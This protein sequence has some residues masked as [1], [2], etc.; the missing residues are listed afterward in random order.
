HD[1]RWSRGGGGGGGGYMRSRGRGNF[2]GNNRRFQ[3]QRGGYSS[4]YRGGRGGF[5]GRGRGGDSFG[6][7]PGARLDEEGDETMGDFMDRGAERYNPYG[8]P[9]RGNVRGNLRFDNRNKSAPDRG[10]FRRLGLPIDSRGGGE[11]EWFKI[12]IPW[13]K[14]ADKEFILKQINTHIDTPFVPTYFHFEDKAAVF[15]VNDGRAAD[16]IRSISKQITMPNGYKMTILVKGSYPPNIPMG[17]DEI[18]KLKVAMS[19]RYD[20]TT[21]ALNLSSL[22]SDGELSKHELYM[23][24][25]RAQV[26]SNVVK[27]ITENIPELCSLDLSNNKL[28]NLEHLYSLVPATADMKVLNLSNN[29][30]HALED[31]RKLQSWKLDW[32]TLTGN[33]LCDKFNDQATY[34]SAV[35]KL[36]PKLQK[37]DNNDLPPAITFDIEARTDLPKSQD[38][39]FP[40]E[41]IKVVA[42][43]FL[44]DYFHVYDSDDRQGLAPAYHETAMFSLSTAYNGAVQNK[45][46]PPIS[47]TYNGA[48]QNKQMSLNAYIDGSRNLIK[49]SKDISRKLKTLKLGP[50]IVAQLCLLPKSLHD[51]NSFIVDVNFA[52]PEM[53][54]FTIQ[55]VFKEV[56][57][58]MDRPPIR[59]FSRTFVTVP[60]GAGMQIVNDMLTVTNASPDQVQSAFKNPAP[61]PSSSPV[62]Q[63]SPANPFVKFEV[64]VLTDLQKQMVASFMNDSRMNSEWSLKCLAQNGWEYEQAGKNFLELQQKGLIPA[65]AFS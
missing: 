3:S 44:K 11:S 32:L 5:R 48:V 60:R 37:L 22:H 4:N 7:G 53:M 30:L 46:V 62:P 40:S 35:R 41:D 1:D 55:G 15:Y 33:P 17:D 25:A 43:K 21:K 58:K 49:G 10:T 23:A 12:L 28:L 52:S 51:P 50:K 29:K 38:S 59:A 57:S 18:Q 54:S 39:Y 27:I 24:L 9:S 61:T 6:P 65:E 14:K 2:R 16:A 42:V 19:S 36:F 47:T 34:V 20:P 13:G 45:Y 26:M 31:L 63:S 64:A 8:R 56:D